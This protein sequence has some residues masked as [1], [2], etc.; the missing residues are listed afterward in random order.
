MTSVAAEIFHREQRDVGEMDADEVSDFF[1]NHGLPKRPPRRP[2]VSYVYI[3]SETAQETG[4]Y[5]LYTVGFYDPSG[6]WVPESDHGGERGKT[7]AAQ[8]TAWLNG[9]SVD[10]ERE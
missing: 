1:A 2:G 9:S 3:E 6:K 10:T 8:H 5:P 4:S 7:S